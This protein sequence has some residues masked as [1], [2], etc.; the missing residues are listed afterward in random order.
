MTFTSVQFGTKLAKLQERGNFYASKIED[1]CKKLKELETEL[2]KAQQ[3]L[4]QKRKEIMDKKREDGNN[5][6]P[7]AMQNKVKA[8]YIRLELLQKKQNEENDF[9]E[10]LKQ[11]IN[12]LRREKNIYDNIHITLEDELEEKKDQVKKVL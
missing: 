2:E 10:T 7:I 4:A 3:S 8:M 11:E 1:E 6:N 12:K 5:N 9:N